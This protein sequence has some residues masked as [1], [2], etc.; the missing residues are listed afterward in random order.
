MAA[1][2]EYLYE[3]F[4]YSIRLILSVILEQKNNAQK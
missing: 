4:I 2:L 3:L 1:V